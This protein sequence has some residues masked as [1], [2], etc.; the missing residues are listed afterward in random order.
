[1]NPYRVASYYAAVTVLFLWFSSTAKADVIFELG[2]G[3]RSFNYAEVITPPGKS[4]QSGI[5]PEGEVTLEETSKS[6]AW[7]LRQ[8]VNYAFGNLSYVGTS[9]APAFTPI[10]ETDKQT[11]WIGEATGGVKL[12]HVLGERVSLYAGANYRIWNR[13]LSNPSETYKLLTVPV[14][15][16]FEPEKKHPFSIGLDISGRE[17]VNGSVGVAFAPGSGFDATTVPVT[18][19]FGFRA[20][21]PIRLIGHDKGGIDLTPWYELSKIGAG[22]SVTLTNNGVPTSSA[23]NEPASSTSQYGITLSAQFS[24]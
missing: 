3:A 5:I 20:E 14:G 23:A 4:T 13:N 10:S 15:L 24:L 21:L 11:F 16:R 7:F 17:M 6:H 1:M 2:G 8:K 22:S 18:A 19:A 12:F 9:Q